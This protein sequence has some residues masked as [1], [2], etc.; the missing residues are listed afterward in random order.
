MGYKEKSKQLSKNFISSSVEGVS[1]LWVVGRIVVLCWRKYD[2]V[3]IF[4]WRLSM[5]WDDIQV[6]SRQRGVWLPARYCPEVTGGSSGRAEISCRKQF[7][8]ALMWGKQV[9]IIEAC[10]PCAP[11]SSDHF[12]LAHF[13]SRCCNPFSHNPFTEILWKTCASSAPQSRLRN[14]IGCLLSRVV[15]SKPEQEA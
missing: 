10:A 2:L 11:M 13:A 14:G 3:I 15:N 6:A 12:S 1:V 8:S 4:I 5:V 7:Y 9:V